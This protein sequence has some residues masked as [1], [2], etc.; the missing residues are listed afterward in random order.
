[1]NFNKENSDKMDKAITAALVKEKKK[2][3]PSKELLTRILSQVENAEAAKKTEPIFNFG[4]LARG[5]MF[6]WKIAAGV[7]AVSFVL[8]VLLIGQFAVKGVD[9]LSAKDFALGEK[10]FTLIEEGLKQLESDDIIF[11]EFT[12]DL[13]ELEPLLKNGV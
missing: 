11:V 9:F 2:V 8:F 6:R 4:N 3:V 10:E 1:M 5:I 7:F 12:N 13:Q